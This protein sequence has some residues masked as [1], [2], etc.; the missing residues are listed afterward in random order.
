[1]AMALRQ[2]L[3]LDSKRYKNNE[4]LLSIKKPWSQYFDSISTSY[5]SRK[6]NTNS[7]AIVSNKFPSEGTAIESQTTATRL[8]TIRHDILTTVIDHIP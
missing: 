7:I 6:R 5:E 2:Y 1:M 4:V 8:V 3:N